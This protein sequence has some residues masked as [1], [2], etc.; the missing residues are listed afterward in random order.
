MN[1]TDPLL[2]D[3]LIRRFQSAAER[4]TE[5]RVKGYSGILEADLLRSEA[6]MEAL[7]HPD[8]NVA[9][10]YSRGP[11]GEIVADDGDGPADKEEGKEVWRK[12]MEMR[13]LGGGDGDFDYR[14]VDD[15]EEWDDN[16][17]ER[18]DAEDEY[19]GQEE[20]SWVLGEDKRQLSGETGVQDF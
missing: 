18:R 10:Q 13:F 15:N 17:Q 2:Y 4:E 7:A 16:A 20:P 11:N 12:V 5:G 3:R 19:F 6:K 14:E 1:E 9:L 8:P